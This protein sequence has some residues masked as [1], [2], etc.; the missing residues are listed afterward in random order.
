MTKHL[1]IITI[2]A[3]F[4]LLWISSEA[5]PT[6]GYPAGG[7]PSYMDAFGDPY[8]V[9]KFDWAFPL[10][11]AQQDING[12]WVNTDA[13]TAEGRETVSHSL[14]DG[15]YYSEGYWDRANSYAIVTSFS[16]SNSIGDWL[17]AI[18]TGQATIRYSIREDYSPNVDN[19]DIVELFDDATELIVMPGYAASGANL[20]LNQTTDVVGLEWNTEFDDEHLVFDH[21]NAVVSGQYSGIVPITKVKSSQD[22]ENIYYTVGATVQL[23]GSGNQTG[24]EVGKFAFTGGNY[25]SGYEFTAHSAD[26]ICELRTYVPTRNPDGPESPYEWLYDASGD[27]YVPTNGSGLPADTENER[28]FKLID[29]HPYW[30]DDDTPGSEIEQV[31]VPGGDQYIWHNQNGCDEFGV[32]QSGNFQFGFVSETI[33]VDSWRLAGLMLGDTFWTG[34]GTWNATTGFVDGDALDHSALNNFMRYVFD[35]DAL[36]VEDAD[37]DGE[38]DAGDDYVLFSVVD[39][40][41]YN[42]Y[43]QW[44][45]TINDDVDAFFDGQYFNGDTIFLYDGTSVTTFFDAGADIF[46]GQASSAGDGTDLWGGEVYYD[47][48]ALDIDFVDSVIPEPST[49]ILIVGAALTCGAGL[50]RK[51][52]R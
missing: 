10:G 14:G 18:G 46:F 40:G 31:V 17:D 30:V 34:T 52:M 11:S 6:S 51:K 22:D 16:L 13:A 2:I 3:V 37:G 47:I 5:F 49:I 48:D 50:L 43:Q 27:M 12:K 39:D 32:P 19:S 9:Y 24:T 45:T 15:V 1:A 4:S 38:F 7:E 29:N 35:I 44:G 21:A 28:A 42:K 20:G 8:P 41:L 36:V 26:I 33:F 23:D 25:H